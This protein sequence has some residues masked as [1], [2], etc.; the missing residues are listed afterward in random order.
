MGRMTLRITDR[1]NGPEQNVSG[2]VQD[3]PLQWGIQCTSGSCGVVTSADSVIPAVAKEGKR[4]VWQ[5]SQ[6]QVLD[7]GADGN[8]AAAPAP[9]SGV[10][11]PACVGNGGETVFLHQGLFVP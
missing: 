2:T 7:G 9:G 3:H 4:A 10:C 6:L 1:L 8:L 11:P 5:L